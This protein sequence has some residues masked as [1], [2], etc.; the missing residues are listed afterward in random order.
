MMHI[1]FQYIIYALLIPHYLCSNFIFY[2][3]KK[4]NLKL[5]KWKDVRNGKKFNEKLV[6]F[7]KAYILCIMRTYFY[8]SL[9]LLMYS[10]EHAN[11]VHTHLNWLFRRQSG[12]VFII[13]AFYHSFHARV[14]NEHQHHHL[15]CA[16]IIVILYI[17]T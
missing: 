4:H 8:S 10:V 11:N 15:P 12:R 3:S 5:F 14:Y 1:L 16:T 9:C 13:S 6:T 7:L 17:Y 2:L